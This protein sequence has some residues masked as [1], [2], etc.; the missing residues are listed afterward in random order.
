MM[1]SL[2]C[3]CRKW[4]VAPLMPGEGPLQQFPPREFL[5]I[6][7][8]MKWKLENRRDLASGDYDSHVA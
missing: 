2:V 5:L 3:C 6:Q 7:K 1:S 8:S 4:L